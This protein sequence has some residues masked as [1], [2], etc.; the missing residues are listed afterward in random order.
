MML[1]IE[2]RWGRLEYTSRDLMAVEE[3]EEP[4]VLMANGGGQFE[5]SHEPGIGYS[6]DPEG[7]F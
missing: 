7:E 3:T 6:W 4:P 5:R 2:T 1:I